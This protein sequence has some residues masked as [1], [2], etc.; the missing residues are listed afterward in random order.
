MSQTLEILDRLIAFPTV[1]RDSNLAL[2]EY[3]RDLLAT[4]GVH[5]K[6]I[7]DD[8]GRKANLFATIGP[9]D[10]LGVMLSG[11]TDV[12]PV[13]GQAWTTDPFRL[14]ERN[15]NLYGRGTADMKGFVAAALRAALNAADCRLRVPLH[16]ALS[17]DEEVGCLGVRRLL[18]ML[19]S[20][21][22]SANCCIV[23]EPTNML[24]A[25]GHKG[26]LA[27]RAICIGREGHSANAPM[28]LNAIHLGCDLVAELR[29]T[30]AKY[31]AG[32]A[33]DDGYG[34]PYTTVHVGRIDGGVALNIVPN[35]CDVHFEIRNVKEDNSEVILDGIRTRVDTILQA[36]RA[37]APEADI[38]FEITSIYPCLD[39]PIHSEVVGFTNSLIGKDSTIKADF[40]TEGGLIS[41]RLGMPTVVCGP[42][43]IA[44]AHKPDEFVSREQLTRCD[45]MLDTLLQ[46][47]GQ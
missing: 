26:K 33:R 46:G 40:G 39:T 25:T 15:G 47:M 2:I 22:T 45:N 41:A 17:Y 12:V 27:A 37:Q 20:A 42:G 35:R 14:T 9:Q 34:V 36:A 18:D 19:A 13:E 44:Q 43:S 31:A 23:G 28:A 6:L 7:F 11:H 1:S 38:R 5:S 21:G 16:I 10:R 29:D 3:A 30:Q 4:K 8:T 24:V 32:G